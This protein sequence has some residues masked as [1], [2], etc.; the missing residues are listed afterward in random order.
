MQGLQQSS[1]LADSASALQV[2]DEETFREEEEDVD[3]TALL[4][5]EVYERANAMEGEEG[6]PGT[7][8]FAKNYL[9]SAGMAA[10]K[11][12]LDNGLTEKLY[13]QTNM[14]ACRSIFK[15]KAA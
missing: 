7:I 1:A 2:A 6:Q 9:D 3:E 14:R 4:E 10:R 13:H 11:K 8:I 12:R 5:D 15:G